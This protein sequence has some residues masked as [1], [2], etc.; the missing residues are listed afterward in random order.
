MRM[1]EGGG[2][3]HFS[4]MI[5][6]RLCTLIDSINLKSKTWYTDNNTIHTS[7]ER[8]PSTSRMIPRHASRSKE[9]VRFK[10]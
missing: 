2:N 5:S 9:N 4:E 8:V 10:H 3:A 1:C 7:F 6:Y